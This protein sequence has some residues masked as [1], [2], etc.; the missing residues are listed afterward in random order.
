MKSLAAKFGRLGRKWKRLLFGLA[1]V[2]ALFLFLNNTSIYSSRKAGFPT[3]L[4]HRG[5]SQRYAVPDRI[6]NCAAAEMLPSQHGYLENTIASMQA[7]FDRG[8][9]VVEFDV[10]PTADG[11]FA[12]FH[13]RLLECRTDGHGIT[14]EHTLRELQALDI[15]Y[16]Y[17]ADGGKTFPFRGKAVRQMPS[18]DE[19]FE[20]FP[21]G[22]FL[23]DVKG[24]Q[25]NDGNLLAAQLSKLPVERRLKLLVFAREVVLA[26]LRERLPDLRMAS[27]SSTAGCLLRY[28]GYGWTGTV[29]AACH[30]APVWV[31]INIAPWLWGWPNR[32]LNRFEGKGSFVILMGT[33]PANEISPGLDTPEDLARVPSNY[34]AGVWTNNVDLTSS[35]WPN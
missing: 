3:V 2:W 34:T 27:A 18:M 7:A 28:I 19:A 11:R 32:F 12:V 21:N 15:G 29:P 13:D 26:E 6:D 16:G 20:K 10:H 5:M 17:T 22:S 25:P 30:H 23:I 4:V 31:P 9:D 8:A 35:R 1:L 24:G 33:Y 14:R